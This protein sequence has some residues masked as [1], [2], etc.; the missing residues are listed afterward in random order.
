MP[1]T[2]SSSTLIS[3]RARATAVSTSA[4]R[5]TPSRVPGRT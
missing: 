2:S 3:Y 5:C 4:P 1:I